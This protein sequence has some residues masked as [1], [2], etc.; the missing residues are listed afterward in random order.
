MLFDRRPSC[1]R[2]AP[3]EPRAAQRRPEHPRGGQM[4]PRATPGEPRGAQRSQ[5]ELKMINFQK[6]CPSIKIICIPRSGPPPGKRGSQP[7]PQRSPEQARGGQ[8]TPE[9][10]RAGPEQPQRSPEPPTGTSRSLKCIIYI[11]V[12]SIKNIYIP[13]SGP[14]P[15][16]RGG[17]QPELKMLSFQLPPN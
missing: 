6:K 11:L 13:S 2:A 5:P 9:E 12:F 3:E 15:G 7:E 4:S 1:P 16:K 10:P 8:R 17:S 14:P